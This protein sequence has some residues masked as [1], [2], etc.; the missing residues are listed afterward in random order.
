MST[1]PILIDHLQAQHWGVSLRL[2]SVSDIA[3]GASVVLEV[4]DCGSYA[5]ERLEKALRQEAQRLQNAQLAI[6]VDHRMQSALKEAFGQIK[7]SFWPRLLELAAEHELDQIKN[8]CVLFIDLKGF[9][10]WQSDEATEKLSLFRGLLK[11]ILAKWK[12]DYPNMEGDSLR[13]TFR[14]VEQALDCAWM[15]Q[16]VLT[17]AGFEVRIGIDRGQISIVHNEVTEQSDIEG[18]AVN[19][20][21]R[22][23]SM[24][25]PG[26]IYVSERIKVHADKVGTQYEFIPIEA[27]LPKGIGSHKAGELIS[28][29]QLTRKD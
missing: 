22:L 24:A 9:S 5:P 16:D 19:M 29:F 11:P 20:A 27:E 17:A 3:G 15:I 25:N 8:F 14:L 1:L 12:A 2:K 26:Q 4:E 23:E 21:A 6:R 13:A 28:L 18:H 7:E 10:E